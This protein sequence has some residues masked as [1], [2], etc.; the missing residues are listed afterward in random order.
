MRALDFA[1]APLLEDEAR[2]AAGQEPKRD[3]EDRDPD[4]AGGFQLGG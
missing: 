1:V 3:V 2:G 4:R